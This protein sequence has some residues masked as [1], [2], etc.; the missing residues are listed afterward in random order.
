M[1]QP[2]ERYRAVNK[3]RDLLED[4]CVPSR[5]PKVSLH[6]RD[7]ARH[8]LKHYP[9]DLELRILAEVSPDILSERRVYFSPPTEE[10]P[11]RKKKWTDNFLF[12]KKLG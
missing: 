4:L 5:T 7:R 6:I 3:V 9:T 10:L 11:K 1:T 8:L 2:D 12:G